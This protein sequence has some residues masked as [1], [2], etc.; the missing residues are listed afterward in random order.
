MLFPAFMNSATVNFI[1]SCLCGYR[2][3][4][5]LG[6]HLGVELWSHVATLCLFEELPDSLRKWLHHLTFPPVVV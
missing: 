2:L 6:G 1:A 4:F 3:S 5:L